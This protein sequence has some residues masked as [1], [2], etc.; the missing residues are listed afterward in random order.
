MQKL[1]F[2]SRARSV[3]S[4]PSL[5]CRRT[6]A[7]KSPELRHRQPGVRPQAEPKG[8]RDYASNKLKNFVYFFPLGLVI[9]I[10]WHFADA[11]CTRPCLFF[12]HV[13]RLAEVSM[14]VAPVFRCFAQLGG[15][16]QCLSVP[17][18]SPSFPCC[19]PEGRR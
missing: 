1:L 9:L 17:A 5:G 19:F 7:V 13:S 15:V 3:G 16:L 18:T 11:K 10:N 14:T 8:I 4:A 2:W 6:S 12:L